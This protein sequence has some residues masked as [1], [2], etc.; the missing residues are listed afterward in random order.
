MS[1]TS[2]SY[3]LVVS[4][5]LIALAA[6]LALSAMRASYRVIPARAA[7]ASALVTSGPPGPDGTPWG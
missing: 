5:V 6:V 3:R 7:A 4:V 2:S 1:N